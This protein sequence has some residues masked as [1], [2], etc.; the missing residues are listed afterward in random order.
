[1]RACS[2]HIFAVLL[3]CFDNPE[4]L[5][6]LICC[7]CLLQHVG[8]LNLIRMRAL[9]DL[10]GSSDPLGMPLL[11]PCPDNP[12][13]L[14]ALFCLC[15]LQHVGGLDLIRMQ[16]LPDLTG[17]SGLVGIHGGLVALDNAALTR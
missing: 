13:G 8:G 5:T 4:G 12:L 3:P 16:A 2:L 9:P 10:T 17:L 6:K 14:T 7:L 1:M 15:C 11:L